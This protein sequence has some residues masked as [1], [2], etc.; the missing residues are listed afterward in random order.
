MNGPTSELLFFVDVACGAERV[1]W[2]CALAQIAAHKNG[3]AS[4]CS[5]YVCAFVEGLGLKKLVQR[6][7]ANPGIWR[8]C[9]AGRNGVRP[10]E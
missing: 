2:Q 8:R 3:P 9:A 6:G 10:S 7:A 5:F 4:D 1:R